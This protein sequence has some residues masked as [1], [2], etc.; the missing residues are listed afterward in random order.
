MWGIKFHNDT[1]NENMVMHQL[2]TPAQ[3]TLFS[4]ENH[5]PN[6]HFYFPSEFCF[7]KWSHKVVVNYSAVKHVLERRLFFFKHAL[8]KTT[9]MSGWWFQ[10]LWKIL[11]KMGIFPNFPGEN[12]TYLKPPPRKQHESWMINHPAII[13]HLLLETT[14]DSKNKCPRSEL[15][16]SWMMSTEVPEITGFSAQGN[17]TGHCWS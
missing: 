15:R 8:N 5:R 2:L 3:F 14:L 1:S 7:G 12:K 4:R 10:H 13:Q 6:F 16:V 17:F 11:V 9:W